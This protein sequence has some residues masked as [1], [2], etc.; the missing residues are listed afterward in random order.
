M[1][2][3]TKSKI[4]QYLLAF[5]PA[6]GIL[7]KKLQAMQVWKMNALHIFYID[8][9]LKSIIF[10]RICTCS[11]TVI[12]I[13]YM[14]YHLSLIQ[15]MSLNFLKFLHKIYFYSDKYTCLSTIQPPSRKVFLSINTE[16]RTYVCLSTETPGDSRSI[17]AALSM[18]FRLTTSLRSLAM[19]SVMFWAVSPLLMSR[20]DGGPVTGWSSFSWSNL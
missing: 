7:C 8:W 15:Y 20:G 5:Y 10:K 4:N 14:A 2:R 13:L 6:I 17:C 1:T 12:S 11:K 19:W 9:K 3:Q 16:V 18:D